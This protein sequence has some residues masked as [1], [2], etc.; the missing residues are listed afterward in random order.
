MNI[1]KR[2]LKDGKYVMQFNVVRNMER[3]NEIEKY[4]SYITEYRF[5]MDL[6]LQIE[7]QF[8]KFNK[9]ILEDIADRDK[10]KDILLEFINLIK[11]YTE[12]TRNK[13]LKKLTNTTELKQRFKSIQHVKGYNLIHNMRNY[14]QHEG[15]PIKS[16]KD[17]INGEVEIYVDIP[18]LINK[19]DN[20][21]PR[22]LLEQQFQGKTVIK[23]NQYIVEAFKT[24][25][26]L[27][28]YIYNFILKNDYNVYMY[29]VKLY[30]FYN[31]Y[32]EFDGELYELYFSNTSMDDLATGKS[33]EIDLRKL[34]KRFIHYLLISQGALKIDEELIK[35]ESITFNNSKFIC[36]ST[37]KCLDKGTAESIIIPACL[38]YDER[39]AL[40][41]VC[42]F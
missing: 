6:Y 33:K 24:I 9:S 1:I 13:L 27:N 11:Q 19:L 29:C 4:N 36:V 28:K 40:T 14:H 8:N 34:D 37:C 35:G 21:Y 31:E 20:R 22:Q 38:N 26:D 7:K 3:L 12:K 41:E 5:C 16:I 17:N 15:I 30:E 10:T 39:S 18:E 25:F 2:S 23:V 32:K 42:R